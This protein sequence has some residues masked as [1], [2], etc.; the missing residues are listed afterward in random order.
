MDTPDDI[1]G[2]TC[3]GSGELTFEP[4]CVIEVVSKAGSNKAKHYAGRYDGYGIVDVEGSDIDFVPKEFEEYCDAWDEVNF[5]Q[6][7][8]QVTKIWSSGNVPDGITPVSYNTTDEEEL[9]IQDYDWMKMLQTLDTFLK[10]NKTMPSRL[11]RSKQEK[12]LEQWCFEQV[13]AFEENTLTDSRVKFLSKIK[14]W[15]WDWTKND[16]RPE[17]TGGTA[18][19]KTNIPEPLEQ[20][21]DDNVAD[22]NQDDDNV[23]DQNQDDDD[24]QDQDDDDD[25]DQNQDDDDQNQDDDQD[26][27]D[28][29]EP[30]FNL[31]TNKEETFGF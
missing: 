29:D 19:V 10:K 22:Q 6:D 4:D 3:S 9:T 27:D 1:F 8:I 16:E 17:T 15:V 24:D 30:N 5:P 18:D 2:Y 26:D 13:S 11:S 7:V 25:Q 21:R 23:A 12:V 31:D 28:D 20:S 14:G